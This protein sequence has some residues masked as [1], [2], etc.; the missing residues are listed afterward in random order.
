MNLRIALF[1]PDIPQNV[2]ATM[3]LCACLSLGLDII[4]PCGFLWD[5]KKIRRAGMDYIDHLEYRRHASWP[6]F[7]ESVKGR[8]LILLTTKASQP[9]T[10]FRFKDSDILIAGRESAG[11]PQ[12]VHARADARIVIPLKRE[13]RSLNVV[14]SLAMVAGEALRQTEASRPPHPAETDFS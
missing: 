13:M 7:L 2:G 12:E 3:R 4:E 8:R 11:V 5:E 6:V 10:Q 1:Q 9:Y 14:N